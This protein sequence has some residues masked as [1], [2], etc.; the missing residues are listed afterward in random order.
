MVTKRLICPPMHQELI[1]TQPR[2]VVE[3]VAGGGAWEM[4][5]DCYFFPSVL[6]CTLRKKLWQHNRSKILGLLRSFAVH[7]RGGG[8]DRFTPNVL[9]C[10]LQKIDRA[11]RGG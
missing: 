6:P 4:N 8:N 5:D 3:C 2:I 7:G 11:Q 9:P 10:T 1:A